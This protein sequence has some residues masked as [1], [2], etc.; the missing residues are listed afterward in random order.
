MY[1]IIVYETEQGNAPLKK[2]LRK[3][4]LDRK[5]IEIAQIKEFINLLQEHG[6]S[7]NMFRKHTIR[8]IDKDIMELRPGNNR[9]LFFGFNNNQ[10]V[11]LHGFTKKGAKTPE[12][13]KSKARN[14][15]KDF[16]RRNQS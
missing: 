11:L 14:E 12:K 4:S 13:E 3:L 16:L 8:N 10:F 5:T 15:M 9:V 6:K 2:F 7:V 1:E